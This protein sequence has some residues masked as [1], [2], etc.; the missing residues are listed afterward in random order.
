MGRGLRGAGCTVDDVLDAL[1]V[2][3]A[4]RDVRCDKDLELA[5]FEALDGEL[6]CLEP[7]MSAWTAGCQVPCAA[8]LYWRLKSDVQGSRWRKPPS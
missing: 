2:N 6:P 3:S 7:S 8:W 4:A 5:R 1:D